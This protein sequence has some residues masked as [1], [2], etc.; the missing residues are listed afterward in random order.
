MNELRCIIL[1]CFLILSGFSAALPQDPG[2]DADDVVRVDTS[3]VLMNATIRDKNDVPVTGLAKKYFR[4]LE[5][6]I[7]QEIE[8][9]EARELSFAAVIL[10]DTSGSMEQRLS[11]AR[12]AAITFLQGIRFGDS[13]AIY[14]FDHEPKL[15]QEFSSRTD[16]SE[17][18]FELKPRGITTLNDAIFT[19]A[20]LLS[21]RPEKRRAIIVLSDGED[22]GSKRSASRALKAALAADATIYTVDMTTLDGPARGQNRQ[23]LRNFAE[24][25][26]G[27]FIPVRNGNVLRETLE[28]VVNELGNQYTI[29]YSSTNAAKDGSWR[30]IELIVKRPN[31]TIRTR[32]GYNAEKR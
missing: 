27:V 7:E 1:L 19:A 8:L 10:I 28:K 5:D 9:F 22:T 23:I 13:V 2:D 25:S 15:V 16:I 6:G 24:Q 17:A 32:K 21:R 12:S 18:V 26:G 31:L 3:L 29:G 30:S 11:V 20:D 4:V 14:S